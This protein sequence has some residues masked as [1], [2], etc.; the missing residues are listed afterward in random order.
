MKSDRKHGQAHRDKEP[1]NTPRKKSLHTFVTCTTP[2]SSI[3][4]TFVSPL[5]LLLRIIWSH[6]VA[7]LLPSFGTNKAIPVLTLNAVSVCGTTNAPPSI[8]GFTRLAVFRYGYCGPVAS[9]MRTS[10]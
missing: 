2:S 5:G 9:T 7:E 1:G 4:K 6:G 10:K 8:Y 3:H